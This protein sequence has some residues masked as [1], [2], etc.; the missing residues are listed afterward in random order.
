[1]NLLN[2]R[3]FWAGCATI[4]IGILILSCWPKDRLE[5][6]SQQVKICFEAAQAEK[7]QPPFKVSKDKEA[8]GGKCL[9]V[10]EGAGD[11]PEMKPKPPKPA[12][13]GEAIYHFRVPATGTYKFW[14][15]TWWNP[16]KG[17]RG[18]SNSFKIRV[19]DLPRDLIYGEDCTYGRWHWPS[20]PA[21]RFELSEGVHVLR[22][23]NRE[24]GIKID[25]I[26]WTTDLDY[27]PMG[28]E[29]LTTNALVKPTSK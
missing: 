5:A 19:D 26:F 17:G 27:V 29:R 21:A 23:K 14:A 1:M 2:S 16:V 22:I 13:S 4:L 8:S 28:K 25:Q 12:I 6:A 7:Y 20:I 24:D 18:C 9:E 11:S 15:R 10:P 3:V